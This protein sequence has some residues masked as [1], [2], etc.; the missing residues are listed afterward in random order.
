[1]STFPSLSE[2][3]HLKNKKSH[4]KEDHMHHYVCPQ[5]QPQAQGPQQTT[6]FVWAGLVG[7]EKINSSEKQKAE[8]EKKKVEQE[9]RLAEEEQRL[10]EEKDRSL[11]A[12]LS[13]RNQ[14]AKYEEEKKRRLEEQ[15]ENEKKLKEKYSPQNGYMDAFIQQ[16]P[17]EGNVWRDIPLK[18]NEKAVKFVQLWLSNW[19]DHMKAKTVG[20]IVNLFY[21]A[22]V[23]WALQNYDRHTSDFEHWERTTY[24]SQA[25]ANQELRY[26]RMR[27]WAQY[28]EIQYNSKTPYERDQWGIRPPWANPFWLEITHA[29]W[30]NCLQAMN[31]PSATFEGGLFTISGYYTQS[32]STLTWNHN[33]N[34]SDGAYI[35]TRFHKKAKTP[36]QQKREQDKYEQRI[37]NGYDDDW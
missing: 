13:A 29:T 36:A 21:A 26:S 17:E 12:E 19:K 24:P 5:P 16:F 15:Q 33:H 3:S 37:K 4:K 22:F 28:A 32:S 8:Q 25:A 27:I 18:V 30:E 14:L 31:S 9:K 35:S 20:E 6:P 10:A 7:G 11:R 1:M 23:P 34:T 2:V